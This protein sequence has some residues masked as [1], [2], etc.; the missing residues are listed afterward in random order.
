MVEL[1]HNF[2]LNNA[3]ITKI[4]LQPPPI[5]V[6]SSLPIP[7]L[8]HLRLELAN[9]LQLTDIKQTRYSKINNKVIDW[10]IHDPKLIEM[11]AADI[12]IFG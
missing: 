7:N 10:S 9:I 8:R 3:N 11:H 1:I 2:R 6:N 12:E 5:P 4:P